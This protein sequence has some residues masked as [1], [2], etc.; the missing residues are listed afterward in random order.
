V[1]FSPDLDP[2][3][4]D[5]A[6][7]R[8]DGNSPQHQWQI[9]STTWLTPRV[10]VNSLFYV[11]RLRQLNIP[12]YTRADA[13]VEFKLTKQPAAIAVGQNLFQA[14]HAEFSPVNTALSGSI[15]PRSGRFQLRWQF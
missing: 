14:A 6:A 5:A 4:S 3:S 13:R 2:A 15:V 12:A 10:E 1:Y 11:G 9:H 8:F 7:S